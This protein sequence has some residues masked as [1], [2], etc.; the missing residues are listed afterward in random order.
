MQNI[1][2]IKHVLHRE[3]FIKIKFSHKC[4]L[5]FR[6]RRTPQ[7]VNRCFAFVG[8]LSL[9]AYLIHIEFVLRPLEQYHLGYWPTFLLTVAITLPLAWI[10]STL[11]RRLLSLRL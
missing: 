7:W 1:A 9:E 2:K 10:L 3:W 11:I 4:S 5:N 6:F 8:S